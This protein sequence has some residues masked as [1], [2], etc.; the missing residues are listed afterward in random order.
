MTIYSHIPIGSVH[1]AIH[2]DTKCI[3]LQKNTSALSLDSY[4]LTLEIS[5]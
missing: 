3:N 1:V 5:W 4:G 2:E